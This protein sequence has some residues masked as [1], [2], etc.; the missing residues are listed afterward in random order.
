MD[1]AVRE[2]SISVADGRTVT[3][4]DFGDP[5]QD[6]AVPVLW[7]HGGPGSRLA[8]AYVAA[9]GREAGLRFIGIDRPGY[10]GSTVHPGRSIA[11]WVPD[12]IEV[13]AHLG[14]D[15]FATTG[16]STGGAYALAVAA[17][18]A[19]RVLAAVPT[20]AMTDMR[21]EPARRTMSVPHAISV[22]DAPDRDAAIAAAV[23][24]HGIDGSKIME[25]ADPDGPAL[26]PSDLAMLIGHPFGQAWMEAV[27]VMFAQGLDGYADDRIAD[28]PGWVSFDVAAVACPVVVLHGEADVICDPIH[29]R[30]TASIV[31][32][33]QLRLVPD[34]GHFSIVDEVVPTLRSVLALDP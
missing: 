5:A 32:G 30:H 34:L 18:A 13:V 8:P 14:I 15:R 11:D 33:A 6:D 4:A 12:A 19:D 29:A 17:L 25:S 22:W 31:P 1:V 7:C 10:G 26:A 20:C 2:G 9:V 28:G 27:P 23:A 24:S 21:F 16:D 3:F